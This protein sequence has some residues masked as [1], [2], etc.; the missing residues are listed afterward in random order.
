MPLFA[1]W[2]AARLASCLV[3]MGGLDEAAD[4][5][6]RARSDRSPLG[7]YE[8]RLAE[9]E[10]LSAR[11]DD[12]LAEFATNAAEIAEDGGHLVSAI[13]LRALAMGQSSA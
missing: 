7:A 12:G 10:L 13:R 6:A 9:A 8:A 1:T 5:L 11:G 4:A 2:A 3:R